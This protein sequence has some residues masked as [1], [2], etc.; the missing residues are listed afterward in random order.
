MVVFFDDILIYSRSEEEHIG[1]LREVSILLESQSFFVQRSKCYFGM[2]ELSYFG[3]IITTAGVRP[4][5][6]KVEAVKSWP[7]PTIVW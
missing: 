4:D 5:P 2:A 1:H 3:H 6:D 7:I